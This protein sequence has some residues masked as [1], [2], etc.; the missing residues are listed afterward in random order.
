M[1]LLKTSLLVALT[2]AAA[3][4][5]TIT[6]TESLVTSGTLNGTIF[7]NELLTVS[8]QGDT[9]SVTNPSPGRFELIGT[10]SVNVATVGSDAFTDAME[11]FVNQ[12]GGFGG[13]VDN[14]TGFQVLVNLNAAFATYA[15]NTSIGP[16]SGTSAGI[17]GTAYPTTGGSL[18]LNGPFDVDH[19]ATFTAA[20]T[21]PEPGT[22]GL[23]SVGI[24]LAFIRRIAR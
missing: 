21:S 5:S 20:V 14:V 3:C 11:A 9:G 2:A 23:L 12:T 18:V 10:G 22:L 8:L 6:V 19:P 4:A 16:L 15:L 17:P 24:G 13:F 7:T 1:T